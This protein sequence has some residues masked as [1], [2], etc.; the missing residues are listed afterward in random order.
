MLIKFIS[1]HF[2]TV[3]CGCIAWAC[4]CAIIAITCT[5][6]PNTA[7]TEEVPSKVVEPIKLYDVPLDEDFQFFIINEAQTHG[8]D[9]T[10]IIS[11]IFHESTYNADAVGDNG[12]SFGLMQVNPRWH[13]ERMSALSCTDLFDPYQNVTIGIDYL[14]ELKDSY[15]GNIEMALTAYNMGPTGADKH[16]FSK[17]NYSS[18]Y[19]RYVLATAAHIRSKVG[20]K[21]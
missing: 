4:I 9:P 10:V 7:A 16:Y 6:A 5:F 12:N 19:S 21:L 18:Q 3:L 14:S 2:R 15:D 11:M 20:E 1:T 17:G 8:I 13:S